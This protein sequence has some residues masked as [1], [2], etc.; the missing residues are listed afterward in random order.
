[1]RLYNKW[2][3]KLGTLTDGTTATATAVKTKVTTTKSNKKDKRVC[4][5]DS[6]EALLL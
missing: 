6:I 5:L 3:E 1:V 4:Q 2:Y